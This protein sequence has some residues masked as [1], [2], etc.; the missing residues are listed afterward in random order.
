MS[1]IN[2][3]DADGFRDAAVVEVLS[4]EFAFVHNTIE[5]EALVQ[6]VGIGA[7]SVPV[8]LKREGAVIDT[9][10]ITL[11]SGRPK[12]VVFKTK[13]DQIG[14]FVYEISIPKLAGEAV[15]SNNIRSFVLQVIR[16]RH[17]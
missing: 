11:E 13:P 1:T 4:D 14:E 10:E 16:D 3:V 17:G 5:I 6:A 15:T 12:K 9:Q 2:V 8:T 7:R